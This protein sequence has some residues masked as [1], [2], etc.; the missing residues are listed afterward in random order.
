MPIFSPNLPKNEFRVGNSESQYQNKNQHPQDSVFQF[1][2]KTGNFDFSPN[3]PKNGFSGRIL[4]NPSPDS[5]TYLKDTMC[6][7]FPMN[8]RTLCLNLGKLAN[9]VYI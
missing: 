9:Y 6:A 8:G 2:G 4:K 7:N 5:Q 1:S 3:L